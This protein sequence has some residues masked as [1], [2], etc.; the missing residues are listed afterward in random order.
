MSRR[1]QKSANMIKQKM[2]WTPYLLI[3][4]AVILIFGV[5]LYPLCKTFYLA[6]QNYNPA[7]PFANGFAGID[8]LRKFLQQ[9]NFIQLCGCH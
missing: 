4:P 5:M 1:R 3:M 7:M 2:V 8:N 9:V 6:F